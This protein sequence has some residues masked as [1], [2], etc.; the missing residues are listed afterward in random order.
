MK[1]QK[2]PLWSI[3]VFPNSKGNMIILPGTIK[4]NDKNTPQWQTNIF[5]LLKASIY[6]AKRK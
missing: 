2:K 3:K 6:Y 4:K 1:R 5:F